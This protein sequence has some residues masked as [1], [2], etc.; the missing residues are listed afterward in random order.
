MQLGQWLQNFF[1]ECFNKPCP[2]RRECENTVGGFTCNCVAGF[3]QSDEITGKLKWKM[4]FFLNIYRF[5]LE[6]G[7]FLV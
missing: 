4:I 3:I 7:P 6:P 1:W 2:A 5:F